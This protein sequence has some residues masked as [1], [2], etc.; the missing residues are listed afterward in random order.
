MPSFDSKSLL[1]KDLNARNGQ[2]YTSDDLGITFIRE[3]GRVA[4]GLLGPKSTGALKDRGTA[5]FQYKR[6]SLSEMQA[7]SGL[8]TLNTR[9]INKI[10]LLLHEVSRQVGFSFLPTDIKDGDIVYDNENKATVTL[11]ASDTNLTYT[12]KC[13]YTVI[14]SAADIPLDSIITVSDYMEF[15]TD[16][17]DYVKQLIQSNSVQHIDWSGINIGIPS[18]TPAGSARNSQAVLSAIPGSGY[19][20][21]V[22]IYFDRFM[23]TAVDFPDLYLFPLSAAWTG[24]AWEWL[25]QFHPEVAEY[26]RESQ[27][28]PTPFTIPAG[29]INYVVP[30]GG[31]ETSWRIMGGENIPV[32]RNAPDWTG[33]DTIMGWDAGI[34]KSDSFN[35]YAGKKLTVR[36]TMF[37]VAGALPTVGAPESPFAGGLTA[38]KNCSIFADPGVVPAATLNDSWTVDVWYYLDRDIAAPNATPLTPM[39]A[40]STVAVTDGNA[41]LSTYQGQ[42]DGAYPG[43]WLVLRNG[44]VIRTP[45]ADLTF[46]KKGWHH[47]AVTYDVATGIWSYYIDGVPAFTLTAPIGA[48]GNWYAGF[49]ASFANSSPGFAVERYRWRKGVKYKGKFLAQELYPQ[50]FNGTVKALSDVVVNKVLGTLPT[51]TTDLSFL[52]ALTAAGEP[53]IYGNDVTIGEPVAYTGPEGNTAITITSN[54]TG[55]YTGSV[56]VY[57]TRVGD[58]APAIADQWKFVDAAAFT[59]NAL[60]YVRKYFP[61]LADSNFSDWTDAEVSTQPVFTIPAGE[62][63]PLTLTMTR[64]KYHYNYVAKIRVNPADIAWPGDNVINGWDSN[65]Y[66]AAGFTGHGGKQTRGLASVNG[67]AGAM[68]VPGKNDFAFGQGLYMNVG[69]VTTSDT[70]PGSTLTAAFTVDFW[71]KMVGGTP[72]DAMRLPYG[73]FTAQP[74]NAAFTPTTRMQLGAHDATIGYWALWNNDYGAKAYGNVKYTAMCLTGWHHVA[75]VYDGNGTGK[76]YMDGKLIN[77]LSYR[78]VSPAANVQIGT[79]GYAFSGITSHLERWRIRSGVKFTGPFTAADIYK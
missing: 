17:T 25:S 73:F 19:S 57:L 55:R 14:A 20:G 66:V 64:N 62:L 48:S 59:G 11:V 3:D 23:S 24:T 78:T 12:G 10:S 4:R 79:W 7:A 41:R 9:R 36:S 33:D 8:T 53:L 74:S 43:I 21:S 34:F 49:A 76:I 58:S 47:M 56:T 26:Y 60:A 5:P 37:G 61:T 38:T 30:A 50:R 2:T 70:I 75:F 52:A 54:N 40:G 51:D 27:F 35:D 6:L 63:P 32:N 22:T 29:A 1:L 67:T 15:D 45:A 44:S 39:A 46:S 18:T 68:P 28:N 71:V 31:L 42:A 72:T 13:V 65:I 16:S 69:T 77:T